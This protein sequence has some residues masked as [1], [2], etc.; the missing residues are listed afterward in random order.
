MFCREVDKCFQELNSNP[1]CRVIVLSGAG[2]IFCAGID[3]QALMELAPALAEQED[4]ARKSKILEG[5]IKSFQNAITSLEVCRKPVL[6]AIHAACIGAG[7]DLITAA[8]MRYCTLDA[9]FQVKEVSKMMQ[10]GNKKLEILVAFFE[11]I[12]MFI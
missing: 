7:V 11:Y 1:D 9:W 6:A 2:K 3:F 4:V 12:N 8:D 10:L 5:S